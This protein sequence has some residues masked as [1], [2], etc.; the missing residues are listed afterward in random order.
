MD[1]LA[2]LPGPWSI[3]V[4]LDDPDAAEKV[5]IWLTQPATQLPR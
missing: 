5:E 2:V 4:S 1:E 3:A